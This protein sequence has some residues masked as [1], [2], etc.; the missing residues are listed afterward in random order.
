MGLFE[1]IFQ[2]KKNKE[3]M[4]AAQ[5]AQGFF[6]ELTA[7]R[8]V[9][10]S[11]GGS[12]Y[13]SEL[14]R[15][16]IDARARHISKLKVEIHGAARPA[17]QAKLKKQPNEWQT[18]SQFLYRLSTILDMH[19]TAFIVPVLDAMLN[20]VG[21]YPV[22]PNKC[23]IV[24]YN[25]LPWVRYEF[26]L[27]QYAAVELSKCAIM[28][29]FQ[30]KH[31][32]FGES[33]AA[34]HDTL[35]LISMQSQGI[36]EAIKAG[37]TY[38]F[39]AK[40]SNFSDPEDL[41]KERKRFTRENLQNN[42]EGGG[43]LLFPNTYTD[44]RQIEAKAYTAD[45]SQIELIRTNVFDYFAVNSDVLQS[46]AYGDAWAS[47]YESVI[48]TF[49]IQFS[50][51]MTKAIFTERE[52]AQGAFV[53]ATSNRLQHMSNADKLAFVKEMGDR[54]MIT[55]NEGREVFNLPPLEGGK[56]EAMPV[57][58]E[59]YSSDTGEKLGTGGN[60]NADKTE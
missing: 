43:I 56:G 21:F 54:G 34:M 2:P 15:S 24:A 17:L 12:I 55:I 57:R 58:G 50:E 4:K 44:I 19:N 16:A 28:T 5:S 42:S 8:P 32:F 33:N 6:K 59:Y 23:E 47:F 10:H 20:T 39:I 51:V 35:D 30:Y 31:D 38:R 22:L 60:N 14:V 41:A 3:G 9:F 46:K 48:E 18:W 11:F 26:N 49:G 13:E 53:I 7:Y 52:Q 25:G 27:G 1:S 37:A 29:R 45:A 40:L 36:K